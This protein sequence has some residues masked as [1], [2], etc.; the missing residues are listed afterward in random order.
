MLWCKRLYVLM[1]TTSWVDIKYLLEFC[2]ILN[3]SQGPPIIPCR[4]VSKAALMMS[5]RMITWTMYETREIRHIFQTRICEARRTM[6]DSARG[7][8]GSWVLQEP[9]RR[10]PPP[11]LWAQ[12]SL[13]IPF[14]YNEHIVPGRGSQPIAY[15]NQSQRRRLKK[16]RGLLPGVGGMRIAIQ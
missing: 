8:T 11:G 16:K 14:E 12:L 5:R 15:K 9:A 6:S 7:P 1:Q 10:N 3:Q 2:K 13:V 4:Q